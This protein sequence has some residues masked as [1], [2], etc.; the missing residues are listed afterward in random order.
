VPALFVDAHL[1]GSLSTFEGANVRVDPANVVV[2]EPPSIGDHSGDRASSDSRERV[3]RSQ[4]AV[5][6]RGREPVAEWKDEHEAE[7]ERQ[8]AERKRGTAVALE[9]VQVELE[10]P[11]GT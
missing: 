5:Q 2:A 10:V 6:Q 11:R 9:L 3:R 7:D 8:R 1:G 4:R